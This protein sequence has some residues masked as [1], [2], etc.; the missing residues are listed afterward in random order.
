MTPSDPTTPSRPDDA[1]AS[2]S[3]WDRV[4]EVFAA[5]LE[6]PGPERIVWLASL[7]GL[8]DA[9]R[10]EVA[11]LLA[12]REDTGAFLTP[13]RIG[14]DIDAALTSEDAG[15]GEKTRRSPTRR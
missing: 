4:T 10:L 11:S 9:V 15:A 1:T 3:H 7:P 2:A 5:A 14:A 13:G 12:A 6:I 8:D